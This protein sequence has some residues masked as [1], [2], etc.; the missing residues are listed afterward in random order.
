MGSG[1]IRSPIEKIIP[2][3]VTIHVGLLFMLFEIS[4]VHY[5]TV[6]ERRV[7]IITLFFIDPPGTALIGLTVTV[8]CFFFEFRLGNLKGK[9][10][11]R[12]YSKI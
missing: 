6:G 10:C 1:K 12:N 7:H 3:Y 5:D 4:W 9:M 2:P 11:R 8:V